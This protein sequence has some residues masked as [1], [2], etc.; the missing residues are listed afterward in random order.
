MLLLFFFFYFLKSMYTRYMASV[1]ILIITNICMWVVINGATEGTNRDHILAVRLFYALVS[2][3]C[4]A[5]EVFS[6]N[7]HKYFLRACSQSGIRRKAGHP[8][9]SSSYL[10]L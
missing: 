5:I 9:S 6:L 8:S 4:A 7:W 10:D 1:E 3:A 2:S